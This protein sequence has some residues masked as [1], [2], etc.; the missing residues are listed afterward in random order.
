MISIS[1]NYKSEILHNLFTN[2]GKRFY[3]KPF[4]VYYNV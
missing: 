1:R 3:E 2:K 4:P